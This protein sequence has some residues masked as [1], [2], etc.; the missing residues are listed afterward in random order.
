MSGPWLWSAGIAL[1]A[2]MLPSADQS[3]VAPTTLTSATMATGVP[4]DEP[5]EVAPAGDDVGEPPSCPASDTDPLDVGDPAGDDAGR[6]EACAGRFVGLG[7]GFGVCG[8][9]MGGVPDGSADEVAR[10]EVAGVAAG[11]V[12]PVTRGL[13]AGEPLPGDATPADVGVA[14]FDVAAPGAPVLPAPTAVATYGG[15]ITTEIVW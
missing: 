14:A 2:S 15:S 4:G 13:P 5:G 10:T 12:K 6:G 1:N 9:A 11:V 3:G 8:A 7:V